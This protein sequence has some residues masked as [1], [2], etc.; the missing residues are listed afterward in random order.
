[1]EHKNM[2]IFSLAV[3]LGLMVG[4]AEA[5]LKNM[6]QNPMHLRKAA[7]G[8][9][10]VA[11]PSPVSK[12]N[13]PV[14]IMLP[15]G[16]RP[17]I[18]LPDGF[19]GNAV[20]APVNSRPTPPRADAAALA[21]KRALDANGSV[22]P[23]LHN[24][25]KTVVP[26]AKA[27]ISADSGGPV[28]P[29]PVSEANPYTQTA[30]GPTGQSK[31]MNFRQF[32]QNSRVVPSLTRKALT[33]ESLIGHK[34]FE[35]T[36]KS[37][38]TAKTAV[39]NGFG[40]VKKTFQPAIDG[41]RDS[42]NKYGRGFGRMGAGIQSAGTQFATRAR[43]AG[44]LIGKGVKRVT[45][46]VIDEVRA[47][48][49]DGR[50][51]ALKDHKWFASTKE[52]LYPDNGLLGR[53]LIAVTKKDNMARQEHKGFFGG[54]RA[55]YRNWKRK[56]RTRKTE[57]AKLA[58]AGVEKA[59]VP[60]NAQEYE[61][62]V[63]PYVQQR[64]AAAKAVDAEQKQA[65]DNA[66]V[67]EK[68]RQR[69]AGDAVVF[70]E[71]RAAR[72]TDRAVVAGMIARGDPN[73]PAAKKLAAAEAQASNAAK[74]AQQADV[75]VSKHVGA[76]QDQAA[77]R[78]QA[79]VRGRAA[80]KKSNEVAT[81]SESEH[82]VGQSEPLSVDRRKELLKVLGL[83]ENAS[84]VDIKRAYRI[85]SRVN[86]PDKGGKV[87]DFVIANEAYQALMG[88]QQYQ[89]IRDA[90][91]LMLE[92]A[93]N[94][95]QPIVTAGLRLPKS[96]LPLSP[97]RYPLPKS[98][99]PSRKPKVTIPEA[100]TRSVGAAKAVTPA[101]TLTPVQMEA[102]ER[103]AQK[104]YDKAYAKELANPTAGVSLSYT[105]LMARAKRLGNGAKKAAFG[106]YDKIAESLAVVN[107]VP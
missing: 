68:M 54:T 80:R 33:G 20:A 100:A 41:A 7:L 62:T 43:A 104:A 29:G 76:L 49:P 12:P 87:Q 66:V 23:Q 1:M 102:R 48:A 27:P 25:S 13:A 97:L 47:A 78:L 72:R 52:A 79:L 65:A 89:G 75:E 37:L 73:S 21:R 30:S 28:F 9:T 90:K 69:R 59:V 17:D 36:G 2:V 15:P 82:L 39:S 92:N 86:H 88:Q 3:L 60:A 98:P 55:R 8:A 16:S 53:A 103:V 61:M 22:V 26:E 91:Q 24:T 32:L 45:P 42:F 58:Q 40:A 107:S 83:P 10:A 57:A 56:R 93:S 14:P 19:E 81:L 106:K 63:S 6:Q 4:N 70:N 31:I 105:Q 67:A 11:A 74:E 46:K 96:P 50:M 101:V 99:P 84:Q 71:A 44:E 94:T 51:Q 64:E 85:S 95:G 35:N 5:T 18:P 34:L 77:T 38:A